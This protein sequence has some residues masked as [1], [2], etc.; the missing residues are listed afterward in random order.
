MLRSGPIADPRTE[1]KE[2]F[3]PD[4]Q[5]YYSDTYAISLPAGPR[6]T[7]RSRNE[8]H[9]PPEQPSLGLDALVRNRGCR[10]SPGKTY[11]YYYPP[12]C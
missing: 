1:V 5:P 11:W 9:H 7:P 10:L 3:A 4:V 6:D 12:Q 2:R 8:T